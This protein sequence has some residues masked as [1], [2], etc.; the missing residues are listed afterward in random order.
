MKLVVTGKDA[1]GV[2]IIVEDGAPAAVV[3]SGFPTLKNTP[4]W[5]ADAPPALPHDGTRSITKKFFPPAGGYRF[6]VLTIDPDDSGEAAEPPSPAQIVEFEALFPGLLDTWEPDEPGMHTSETI[7]F[8]IV[9]SGAVVLEVDDRVERTLTAGDAFVQI[10][11][12]H[13]W[14]NPGPGPVSIAV[15]M[16]GAAPGENGSGA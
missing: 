11:A 5:A 16:I 13:R 2:S 12:R 4:L 15:M 7:D 6:F 3:A 9:L 10:A 8:G 14:R 1:D